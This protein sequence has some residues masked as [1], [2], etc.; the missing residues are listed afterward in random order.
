MRTWLLLG[1]VATTGCTTTATFLTRSRGNVEARIVGGDRQRLLLQ[2]EAGAE[3]IVDRADV[4]D[5]DHPGNV[6]ALLGGIV[7]FSGLTNVAVGA[8]SC[9]SSFQSGSDCGFII[10]M[11]SSVLALGA[12]MLTWGLWAWLTSR[13]LVLSTLETPQLPPGEPPAPGPAVPP[14]ARLL[15]RVE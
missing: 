8:L 11:M 2:S 1:L 10:G 14:S 15:P 4:V 12:G 3:L 7:T 5:I 6:V 13:N 9:R